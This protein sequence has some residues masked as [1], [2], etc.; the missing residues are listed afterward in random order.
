[1]N[2]VF[3]E[4][5]KY[6]DADIKP[7][8][9]YEGYLAWD[10]SIPEPSY[11]LVINILFEL[12]DVEFIGEILC[13]EPSIAGDT[14]SLTAHCFELVCAYDPNDKFGVPFRGN[15][16]PIY[17]GEALDYTIRF[18]NLGNDTAFTVRVEDQLDNTFDLSTF[19][20]IQSSHEI[21]EYFITDDGFVRF[22][23]ENIE[24]PAP[25]EEN[26][27]NT[28]FVQFRIAPKTTAV[29]STIYTNDASI[30]F[31][32][33]PAII[34]NETWHILEMPSA[35]NDFAESKNIYVSPNPTNGDL[36]ITTSDSE[37]DFKKITVYNIKGEKL[38]QY[39]KT[40]LNLNYLNAGV[41]FIMIE[42]NKGILRRKFVKL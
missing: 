1:M 21:K 8:E 18:E 11:E 37:I 14:K 29:V 32:F 3:S 38:G 23:F 39:S 12:P 15:E 16:N 10:V 41:Y 2:Y 25:S 33:N 31:D 5:I 4:G 9:E 19:Q 22:L 34:T 20:F 36:N 30:F 7:K 40:S 42:T 24:L 28:G 35:L 17:R 6:I 26:D 13:L 27:D